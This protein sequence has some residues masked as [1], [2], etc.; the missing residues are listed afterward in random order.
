MKTKNNKLS[1][2]MAIL[3]TGLSFSGIAQESK[4]TIQPLSK[5]ATKGYVYNVAK[6]GAGNSTI[7]YKIAA[8]KKNE[9]NLFEEYTFDKDLKFTGSKDVQEKKEQHEN[10]IITKYGATVGGGGF[11]AMSMK[12]KLYKDV[13][14]QTWSSEQKRY[15]TEKYISSEV[16]KAKNEE[17]KVYIAYASYSSSDE[18]KSDVFNIV[19][20]DSKDKNSPD[21]FYTL[22]FNS[23][24][25]LKVSPIDLKG[26]YSVIFCDQ[27]PIKNEAGNVISED[28]V[29]VFAPKAGSPDASKYVYLQY[30][31]MGNLKNKAEFKSPA[32]ALLITAAYK[33]GEDVYFCGSSEKTTDPY[34][35]VYSEYASI[36][37]FAFPSEGRNGYDFKW[38]KSS[39]KEMDNFHLLKFT[40]NQM[41]FTSTTPVGDFKSKF[42]TAPNDK[43]ANAY[44]GKKFLIQN[45]NVTPSGDYLIAG[46]LTGTAKMGSTVTVKTY[47]DII[48]LHFDKAGNL[49]AQYGIG[50]M[51]NDK[52]SEIFDMPQNFYLSSDGKKLFWEILEVKGVKGYASFMDANTGSAT[53]YPLY[54]PRIGTIDL[55]NSSISAFKVLGDEKYF[56]RKDFTSMF[57]EKEKSITYIG[58]DD[59]FKTLWI[60][61]IIIK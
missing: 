11:D 3:F 2:A 18:Q 37:N 42:K 20:I 6:D 15:V 4:E 51:N 55:E 44:K 33:K 30:D 61:K 10:R 36:I 34:E 1:Y 28:V 46:Q 27:L 9:A 43:G 47:E 58:H 31:I 35:K 59:D 13:I 56:L 49:K 19:K 5:K 39:A 23:T 54:F 52:K 32:S 60:G 21:K 22:L 8:A 29:V 24:L 41:V 50:K 45:F 17:N 25:E 26:S 53:F 57:D 48:C 14:S 7:T 12:L 40:G 16:V 38:L